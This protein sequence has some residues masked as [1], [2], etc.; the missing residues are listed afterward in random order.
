MKY[1]IPLLFL[2]I[3]L[4]GCGKVEEKEYSFWLNDGLICQEV[5]GTGGEALGAGCYD[6]KELEN[7]L[8]MLLEA[9]GYVLWEEKEILKD[10]EGCKIIKNKTILKKKLNL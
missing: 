1:I 10:T 6:L 5:Y 2:V 8:N 4:S 3:L 9:E 7:K